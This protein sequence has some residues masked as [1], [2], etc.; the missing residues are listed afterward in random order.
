MMTIDRALSILLARQDR[1]E[2]MLEKLCWPL[3]G[4]LGAKWLDDVADFFLKGR[5]TAEQVEAALLRKYADHG[6]EDVRQAWKADVLISARLPILV[7]ALKA[8]EEGQYN[9]SVPVL[10][11]Q[12]EGMVAEAKQHTGRFNTKTLFN[13]LEPIATDGSRFQQIAAKL[14]VDTLWAGFTHG[15]PPPPLSRHAILHG[16]DAT[17]GTGA[18]S[19]RAILYFDIIRDALGNRTP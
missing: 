19:L 18:N 8:H 3:P 12:L 11:A 13:Y 9:L 4:H 5:A 17:Y 14:V 15:L 16:A 1:L 2:E 7:D 6:I 10:L